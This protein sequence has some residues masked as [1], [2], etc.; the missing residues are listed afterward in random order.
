MTLRIKET[1]NGCKEWIE[2]STEIYFS[3]YTLFY[4]LIG[5]FYIIRRFEI[6]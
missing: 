1:N 5:Y 3:K 6:T 2:F 4:I